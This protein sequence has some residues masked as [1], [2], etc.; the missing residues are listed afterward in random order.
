MTNESVPVSSCK[1]GISA[2]QG[3]ASRTRVLLHGPIVLTLLRLGPPN[4][5]V[6]VV[7]IA[8]TASVDAH[9]IGRFG[10]NALAGISLVFPLIM[11]MQ[12][13]ANSSMGGAIAAAVARAIGAGR[14]G[15]ASALVIHGVI[16]AAGMAAIFALVL[17]IGGPTI[18]RLI[19]GSGE[20]LAAAVEYSNALFAGSLAYWMLSTLTSVVRGAGHALVLAVVYLA[21][22]ALHIVLVPV[23]MFGIGPLPALGITGAGVATVSSFTASS[24]VLAWYIASGRTAV[25]MS[26]RDVRLTRRLFVEI[27]RV[28]VPMSLQPSLNNVGLAFLTGF[29]GSLG[30]AQLAGFGVAAR[31]EYILYPL[32]F[33]IDAGL[34]AIV[35]TNLGAGNYARV[36]RASW[37]AAGL[38]GL[39]T[40]CIGLFGVIAPGTWASLFTDSAEVSTLAARYLIVI[41]LTYPFLGVGLTLASAFQAAGRPEWAVV[42]ITGRVSV[43]IVG[44]W[45]AVHLVGS[46]LPGL[47]LVAGSGLVVYGAIEM[48]AFR[49]GVWRTTASPA[50][51][52]PS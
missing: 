39:V 7:L 1:P 36:V 45:I 14:H 46:G 35:G 3:T 44:G 32:T 13:V 22:E 28:G 50:D 24:L 23:L 9:F 29:V 30:A 40:G 17:L 31:L 43:V 18:Y 15:D 49:A 41:G 11:L 8:V 33:G 52:K 5:V 34:L 25:E 21:A 47:A 16:I 37:I 4:I 2:P 12:Q 10:P 20:V 48:I 38:A 6:N 26:F 27:L 42:G 51:I 19:G